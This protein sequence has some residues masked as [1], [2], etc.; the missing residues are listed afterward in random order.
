N[1]TVNLTLEIEGAGNIEALTEPALP[2]LTNW[3]RFDSQTSTS[4]NNREDQV[5]GVRRFERILV[6]GQPGEQ[7]IPPVSF[8]FYD[9]EQESYQ[10]VSTDPLVINVLPGEGEFE[11]TSEPV[12]L[13]TGELGELKAVPNSLGR[14]RFFSL[15]NPVYWLCWLPPLLIVATIWVVQ[16]QRQRL[17]TDTGYARRLRAKRVAHRVLQETSD[18]GRDRHSG[19]QRALLGYLSDKLNRPTAGLTTHSLIKILTDEKLSPDLIER[20]RTILNQIETSRFA[21]V[22]EMA[23]QSLLA[24]TRALIDDLEMAFGR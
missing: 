19:A 15:T 18:S 9:P 3:R 11:E 17:L 13:V 21:P 7:L 20:V 22:G 14:S 23:T 5:F 16:M 8:S 2:E 24:E 1:D 10:T 4:L 6:P 12:D